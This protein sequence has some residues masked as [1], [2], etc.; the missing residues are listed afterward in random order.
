MSYP[1][2]YPTPQ[3]ANIQ[4]FK[5]DGNSTTGVSNIQTWVKPQGASFVWFTLIGAGGGGGAGGNA[6]NAGGGGGGGS[7]AVTNC[8]VPAFLIPDNLIIDVGIAGKGSNGNGGV[9]G[10]NGATTKIFTSFDTTTEI[11]QAL[12]GGGGQASDATN[13]GTGG[14]GAGNSSSNFFSCMGFWQNIA[15]QAGRIGGFGLGASTTTFL[16]GGAGGVASGSGG[17]NAV[18]GNYDYT[19]QYTTTAT[20]PSGNPGF[21]MTSPIIVGVGGGNVF[22]TVGGN[23]GGIG[24]G[25][26]GSGDEAAGIPAGNGGAG[27]VVI[28]TW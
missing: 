15:G 7:G 20:L 17:P 12:G 21:F 5:A 19:N 28:I 11:L 22:P 16:S 18:T 27:M 9:A 3:G 1:I 13:G 2:N 4:I 25:G 6:N 14:G 10:G 26:G 24:C 8:M 23:V